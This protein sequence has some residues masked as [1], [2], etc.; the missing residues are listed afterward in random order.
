MA[1]LVIA[2]PNAVILTDVD[3]CGPEVLV[4]NGLRNAGCEEDEV[5]TVAREGGNSKSLSICGRSK[6]AWQEGA[7]AYSLERT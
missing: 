6:C 5:R 4:G 1:R 7:H 2:S 3:S